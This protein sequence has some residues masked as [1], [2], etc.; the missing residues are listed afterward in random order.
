MTAL[1]TLTTKL[2]VVPSGKPIYDEA[3]TTVGLD[4]EGGGLFV[5]IR[6]EE[7][8]STNEVKIDPEE[9]PAIRAAVNRIVR[10]CVKGEQ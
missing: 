4:D 7:S 2:C 6:Q 5:V 10:E 9:W 3:A 1:I 8:L